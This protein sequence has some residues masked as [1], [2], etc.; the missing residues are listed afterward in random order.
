[1]DSLPAI[2]VIIPTVGR[3][4]LTRAAQSALSQELASG[5]VEV[6][7]VNDTGCPLDSA[8]DDLFSD[9]RVTVLTTSRRRQSVA[10]NIGA[11]VARG[12]AYLFLDDDDW[13]LPG[14]LDALAKLLDQNDRAVAAYGS[15]VIA[16]LTQ[17][18]DEQEMGVFNLGRRGNCASHLLAG[19]FVPLGSSLY[20]A[21]AFWRVGGFDSALFISEDNDL[22][23][24][25]SVEGDFEQVPD[26]VF[27]LYRGMTWSTTMNYAAA[28]DAM[29]VSREKLL[30]QPWGLRRLIAS[31]DSAYLRARNVKAYAASAFWNVR[32][33]NML[34]ACRRVHSC[35]CLVVLSVPSLFS[36]DFW[37]AL[38]ESQFQS[39]RVAT[40]HPD[41]D[42]ER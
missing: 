39:T 32:H 10:R 41:S 25:I 26:P 11:A 1:M 23:R 42:G 13:L 12:K 33:A 2:S 27:V 38:R 28:V 6:I 40:T 16:G 29:R 24:R 17:D 35:L 5:W 7:I 20:R 8:F 18:G 3:A 22:T 21:E 19:A 31:A 15:Y 4:T 34:R 9:P 36:A 30:D 37:R 14:G